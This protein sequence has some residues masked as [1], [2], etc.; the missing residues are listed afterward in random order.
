[1]GYGL[2]YLGTDV[3]AAVCSVGK[4]MLR[5]RL[6]GQNVERMWNVQP[7]GREPVGLKGRWKVNVTKV[8]EVNRE[9]MSKT[10]WI[11]SIVIIVVIIIIV[12]VFVLK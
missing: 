4:E 3:A 11:I 12:V 7:N 5:R 9:E 1:M 10:N 6:G 2:Q 8:T